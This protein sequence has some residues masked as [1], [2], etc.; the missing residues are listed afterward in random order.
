MLLRVDVDSRIDD[1]TSCCASRCVTR[2]SASRPTRSIASSIPFTQADASTTRRFGGTGLGLAIAKEVVGALGG[3]MSYAPNPGG[4]S[5]FAFTAP[6][7]AVTTHTNVLDDHARARL[8][9]KRIMIC[10]THPWRGRAL[11]EQL[12][13]WRV[14]T[15]VVT[16][17]DSVVEL[18][19]GRGRRGA[20]PTR[21]Y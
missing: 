18:S 2:A 12:E 3:E 10:D 9:T 17:P 16:D 14:R 21:P 4:G 5:V 19:A 15:T 7:T 13:W 6:L 11:A 20:I 8:S 1:Q